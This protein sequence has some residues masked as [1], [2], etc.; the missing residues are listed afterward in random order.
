MRFH[1]VTLRVDPK[2]PT[3]TLRLYDV[4]KSEGTLALIVDMK[5]L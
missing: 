1:E 2:G 5:V 3:W 4:P